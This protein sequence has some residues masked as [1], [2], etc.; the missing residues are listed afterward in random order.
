MI[1]LLLAVCVY[2]GALVFYRPAPDSLKAD[3]I[4]LQENARQI[5][6]TLSVGVILL[7]IYFIITGFTF[8]E[9]NKNLYALFAMSNLSA[10]AMYWPFQLFTHLLI[11]A[12]FMHLFSN[13]A[14][15]GLAAVYE[16]RV[17]SQRFLMVLAA[18][19][20]AS[21]LSIFFYKTPVLLSGISGGVMALGVAYFTDHQNITV[22]EWGCAILGFTILAVIF[23]IPDSK[24]LEIMERMNFR[25]D[26]I[27]HA[28]GALGGILYC[29]LH[30]LKSK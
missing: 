12:N 9:P 13:V 28:F 23:S 27:G 8:T 18:G 22:K 5:K 14:A 3:R 16:R 2:V 24:D 11:H 29:R 21:V 10:M 19:S 4:T 30:P 15:I 26:H 7:V 6:A 1:Y 20:M 17:G 25:V